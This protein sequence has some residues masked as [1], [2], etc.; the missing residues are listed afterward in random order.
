MVSGPNRP[1]SLVFVADIPRERANNVG[2][3]ME[4][5]ISQRRDTSY[6]V[7]PGSARGDSWPAPWS[8]GRHRACPPRSPAGLELCRARYPAPLLRRCMCLHPTS[9]DG[10][11][12]GGL[13]V[14]QGWPLAA[15]PGWMHAQ[16]RI[17]QGSEHVFPEKL[18]MVSNPP[19]R[20]SIMPSA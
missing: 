9:H 13:A 16:S 12:N 6:L 14:S 3:A 20:C 8:E 1:P 7:W 10:L 18:G 15:S 2:L 11:G 5:E 17:R 19:D 4:P